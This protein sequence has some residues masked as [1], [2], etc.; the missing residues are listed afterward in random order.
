MIVGLILVFTILVGLGWLFFRWRWR[1][2]QA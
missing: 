1:R 2:R